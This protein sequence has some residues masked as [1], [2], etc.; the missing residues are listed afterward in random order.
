[1]RVVG[2]SAAA[3]ANSAHG[4]TRLPIW[5]PPR[6]PGSWSSCG[7]DEGRHAPALF[8]HMRHQGFESASIIKL[9]AVDDGAAAK[10]QY[11]FSVERAAS[12]RITSS[13]V[14]AKASVA[15]SATTVRE[16]FVHA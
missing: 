13:P 4:I 16:T 6:P 7:G 1:M 12:A 15:S 11:R 3:A 5:L 9:A 14:R 2:G 10:P 8:G